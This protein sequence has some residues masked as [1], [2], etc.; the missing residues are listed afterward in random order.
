MHLSLLAS[1]GLG[2]VLHCA[3]PSGPVTPYRQPLC[4]TGRLALG[5]PPHLVP[6]LLLAYTSMSVSDF[7]STVGD[8]IR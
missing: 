4:T 8:Y 7:V 5:G 1:G 2:T 6:P 3:P